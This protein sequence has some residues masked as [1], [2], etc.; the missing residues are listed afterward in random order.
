MHVSF[1][2]L[3]IFILILF[4][5]ILILIA[6]LSILELLEERRSQ[7]ARIL[8]LHALLAIAQV[9][10]YVAVPFAGGNLQSRPLP[11]RIGL[12]KLIQLY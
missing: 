5:A 3:L 2:M 6:I 12:P 11:N 1:S 9:L 8:I 10:V 7:L 4:L